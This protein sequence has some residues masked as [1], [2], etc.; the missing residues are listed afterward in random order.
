MPPLSTFLLPALL[1]HGPEPPAATYPEKRK[2]WICEG[3][4]FTFPT[5]ALSLTS[6]KGRL[7]EQFWFLGA[8]GEVSASALS[9]HKLHTRRAFLWQARF[10]SEF[11][12]IQGEI[13]WEI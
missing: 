8:L 7:E 10:K 6:V 12:F 4:L 11:G 2:R 1:P 5:E 3:I 13:T 9:S